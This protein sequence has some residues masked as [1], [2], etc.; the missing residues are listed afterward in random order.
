MLKATKFSMNRVPLDSI[1]VRSHAFQEFK[2]PL[3]GP[4]SSKAICVPTFCRSLKKAQNQGKNARNGATRRLC[5]IQTHFFEPGKSPMMS[6]TGRMRP[7]IRRTG[8]VTLRIGAL[9]GR[10]S[11]QMPTL[12]KEKHRLQS[13]KVRQTYSVGLTTGPL[14]SG[15][16]KLSQL[17][18]RSSRE[19]LSRIDTC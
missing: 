9:E 2:L 12:T 8:A 19:R 16:K 7:K 1:K 10:R 15:N 13:G 6:F 4:A 5:T 11:Q 17:Q 3:E 14:S 18:H